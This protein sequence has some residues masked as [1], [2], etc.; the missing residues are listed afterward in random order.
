MSVRKITATAAMVWALAL[1]APPVQA[2]PLLDVL[3][4]SDLGIKDEAHI[5]V[6]QAGASE[7][8]MRLDVNRDGTIDVRDDIN[9]DGAIDAGDVWLAR[10]DANG[11]GFT[12]AADDLNGDGTLDL[13]D[14][15]V[16]PILNSLVSR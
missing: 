4:G 7:A 5:N 2:F 1:I 12:N 15:R 11:D 13:A 14:L 3:F 9:N 16:A 6:R 8:L 10:L